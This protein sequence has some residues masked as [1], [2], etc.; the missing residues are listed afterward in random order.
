MEKKIVLEEVNLSW[1][2]NTLSDFREVLE[3]E[4]EDSSQCTEDRLS[5][6]K[7]MIECDNMIIY[8]KEKLN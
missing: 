4:F 3:F 8:L 7:Q 1:I 2:I 5:V 6:A